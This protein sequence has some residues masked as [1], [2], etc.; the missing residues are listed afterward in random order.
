[1]SRIDSPEIS[2]QEASL[3]RRRFVGTGAAAVAAFGLADASLLGRVV[4]AQDGERIFH[5]AWPYLDPPQGHFNNFVTNS[6]LMTPNIYGDMV[7]QPFAL[8]NWGTHEWMP[9]MATSW[10]FINSSDDATPVASADDADAFAEIAPIA[11]G[12]DTF[13]ITLRPDCVWD[14]GTP[15]TA[16]DVVTTFTLQRLMSNTV[17]SY[18]DRID[19]LDDSTINFVMSEP[20]TI[21]QRYILRISTQPTAIYGEW[22]DK[23]TALFEEGKTVDDPEWKQLLDQFVQF[24]PETV[25]ANGPF[26]ID[27]SS[28]TNSEMTLVRNDSAWNADQVQFDKIR[29]FN[30]RGE[31]IIAIILDK[32]VDYGTQAFPPAVEKEM[33]GDGFRIVRPPVYSGPALAS[34]TENS[35]SSTTSGC[36]RR[37]PMPSIVSR[38]GSSRSA[39]PACLH[40]T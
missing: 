30:G 17:W 31:T 19:V 22:A 40:A 35:P 34:T 9:L 36:A 3:S 25:I 26:T 12:A 8:Y 11:E 1:M 4:V 15:F 14:D 23:A 29:N 27:M 21:A 6:I 33:L 16:Q 2:R 18:I 5:A 38:T 13:Q 39:N 20:S 7:W 37:L 24:R 10:A 32:N 28:I